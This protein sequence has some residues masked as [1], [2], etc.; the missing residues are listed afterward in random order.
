MR[1]AQ[2]GKTPQTPAEEGT[3]GVCKALK[4]GTQ[5]PRGRGRMGMTKERQIEEERGGGRGCLPPPSEGPTNI[6]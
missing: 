6:N 1:R 2:A 3:A 4:S 5:C